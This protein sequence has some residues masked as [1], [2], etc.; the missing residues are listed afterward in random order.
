MWT[1]A[2]PQD[3]PAEK[4]FKNIK[5]L[6]GVPQ[7]QIAGLMDSYNKALGV[8]CDYCHAAGNLAD[9]S[10]PAHKASVRDIM[11]TREIN[12]KYKHS[13]DCMSCHQGKAKPTS[14]MLATNKG[15]T[16]TVPPVT[17]TTGTT[18]STP[19]KNPPDKKTSEPA[20]T[21]AEPPTKVTYPTS[22]SGTKVLFPHDTHM[23]LDCAKC[24]HTGENTK[25]DTCHLHNKKTSDITKVTF[26]AL[27]HDQKA[28]RACWGC[29]VKSSAGPKT[30]AGCH[31]K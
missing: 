31:K 3:Q 16:T 22:Y 11:M 24:H 17:P 30:C 7:G 26:Y 23:S 15:P 25:C 4:F 8:S 18:K 27:S 29:H 14:G 10:K 13:V 20:K 2:Q 9:D 5:A 6:K 12:D 28:E 21:E 19:D 1:S